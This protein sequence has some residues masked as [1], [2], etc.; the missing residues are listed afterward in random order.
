MNYPILVQILGLVEVRWLLLFDEGISSH[1]PVQNV[2]FP[3]FHIYYLVKFEGYLSLGFGL[4]F[5]GIGDFCLSQPV[6]H[7]D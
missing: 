6:K 1:K 5:V 4:G 3:V 7:P 2:L